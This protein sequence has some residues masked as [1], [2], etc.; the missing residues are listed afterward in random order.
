M[1]NT[2]IELLKTE[3]AKLI[4]KYCEEGSFLDEDG[5]TIKGV[6]RHVNIEEMLNDIHLR[7]AL[8]IE[9]LKG[10]KK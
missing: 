2:L 1:L 4:R 9:A 3:D 10:D 8:I 6:C 7:D 5:K